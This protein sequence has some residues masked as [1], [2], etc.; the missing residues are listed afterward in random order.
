MFRTH[1]SGAGSIGFLNQWTRRRRREF[2]A[3]HGPCG[4]AEWEWDHA[5][6]QGAEGCRA[7]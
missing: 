6:K 3:T 7:A 2:E 4:K 5:F 1:P